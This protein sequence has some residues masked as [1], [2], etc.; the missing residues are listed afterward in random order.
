MMMK[1]L[2]EH[3]QEARRAD[4]ERDQ[5]DDDRRLRDGKQTTNRPEPEERLDA[6]EHCEIGERIR[7]PL[8]HRQRR[9]EPEADRRPQIVLGATPEQDREREVEVRDPDDVPPREV[10]VVHPREGPRGGS[11]HARGG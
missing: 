11:H 3:R 2:I 5:N 9:D 4:C 10:L 8:V 1:Q 7:P 6:Q